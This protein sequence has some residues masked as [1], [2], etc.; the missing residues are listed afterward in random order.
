MKSCW[1][2]Y[3]ALFFF[4]AVFSYDIYFQQWTEMPLH[5]FLSVVS[6]ALLTV[7]CIFLGETITGF[8]LLVP[9]LVI[10]LFS[11]VKAFE[12]ETEPPPPPPPVPMSAPEPSC[13]DATKVPA[14]KKLVQVLVSKEDSAMSKCATPPP[15]PAPVETVKLGCS[16]VP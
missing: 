13:I 8:I 14:C 7:A 1:P 15:P 2:S 12:R 16:A 9:F 3:A 5:A 10:F 6:I 11:V 4:I